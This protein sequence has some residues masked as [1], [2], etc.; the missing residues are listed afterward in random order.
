MK[1]LKR[2]LVAL[3]LSP[4]DEE[5]VAYLEGFS[6]ALLPDE[7]TFLHVSPV[8]QLPSSYFGSETD[9]EAYLNANEENVSREL[10]KLVNKYFEHRSDTTIK[11]K[12][13][14]GNP[15]KQLIS[16]TSAYEPDLL[17]A[18]KKHR[19]GGSGIVAQ[20]LARRV[21]AAILFVTKGAQFPV[22]K[23]LIPT[24]YSENSKAALTR[25]INLHPLLNDP[26]L[27]CIH[28]YEVPP[29]LAIQIGRTPEQFDRIVHGNA[30]EAM[31][32]FL[33]RKD[34]KHLEVEQVLLKTK[35]TNPSRQIMDYAERNHMGLIIIGAKGHTLLESLLMGSTTEKLLQYDYDIPILIIRK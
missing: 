31:Q 6:K 33:A 2:L 32:K 12:I 3:D 18:G 23:I 28:I 4:H 29:G 10:D 24:D 11:T 13:L 22:K 26:E 14:H 30:E 15:L 25:A 16:Y 1:K 35:R 20:K 8:G 7:I 21:D 17:L 9:R 34:L 19:T 5:M 27:H